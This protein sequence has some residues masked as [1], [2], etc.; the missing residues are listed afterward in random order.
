[1]HYGDLIIEEVC[2][3]LSMVSFSTPRKNLEVYRFI[4]SLYP[5]Q[6]FFTNE[7]NKIIDK[8]QKKDEKGVSFVDV[9]SC[10]K[11]INGLLHLDMNGESIY[12][13]D[14]SE[15]DFSD[16]LCQYPK[17][18]NLWLSANDIQ[19]ILIFIQKLRDEQKE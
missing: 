17:D 18:K 2:V 13:P 4:S 15:D 8:H 5:M 7:R 16:E 11:D 19:S 10:N 9:D 6:N 12:I 3:K 1:M 14:I